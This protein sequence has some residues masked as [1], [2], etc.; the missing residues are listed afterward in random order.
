M[1][2]NSKEQSEGIGEWRIICTGSCIFFYTAYITAEL[3]FLGSVVSLQFFMHYP[4]ALQPFP[5]PF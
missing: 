4:E 3:L 2:K 5:L 1:Q